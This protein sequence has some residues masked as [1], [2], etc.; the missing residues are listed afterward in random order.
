V[1]TWPSGKEICW[2]WR[3]ER[4]EHNQ[5]NVTIADQKN[6]DF[7][8]EQDQPRMSSEERKR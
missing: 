7:L 6:I 2:D 5:D 8:P 4:K 3:K 1:K